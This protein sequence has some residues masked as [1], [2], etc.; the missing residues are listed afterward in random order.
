M[1]LPILG[2]VFTVLASGAFGNEPASV[3]GGAGSAWD[4]FYAG[5]VLGY[6]NAS[7][8]HCDSL[9]GGDL[10][11]H[12]R[13]E[14]SAALFGLTAGYNFSNAGFVYGFEADIMAGQLDGSAPD[15]GSPVGSGRDHFTN[16]T[17]VAT[18]R[19][20]V[21]LDRGMVMPYVTAGLAFMSVEAGLEP[22]RPGERVPSGTDIMVSPVAGLGAEW[23]LASG[24]SVKAEYLHVFDSGAFFYDFPGGREW[25]NNPGCSVTD[26]SLDMVRV[27]LNWRF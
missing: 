22:A 15:A 7:S 24:M 9:C 6:G 5:A 3:R 11:N 18:L 8:V 19:G 16:I 25:C 17:S 23:M 20:R 21:G 12:P 1:R 2:V 10:A 13:P 14:S 4:G 27:G 26:I